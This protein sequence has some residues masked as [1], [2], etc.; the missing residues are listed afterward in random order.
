MDASF[1][2][3]LGAHTDLSPQLDPARGAQHI[4]A[5]FENLN[6]LSEVLDALVQADGPRRSVLQLLVDPV[7]VVSRDLQVLVQLQAPAVLFL[8]VTRKLGVAAHHLIALAAGF[9]KFALQT[10]DVPLAFPEQV[11]P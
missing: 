7:K 11:E 2:V 5:S 10:M 8:Q 4:P 9:I 6:S 1:I 3:D